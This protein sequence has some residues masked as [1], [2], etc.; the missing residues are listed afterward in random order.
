M[1]LCSQTLIFVYVFHCKNSWTLD[2]TQAF[3]S[4][5]D[6][7]LALWICSTVNNYSLDNVTIFI[8]GHFCIPDRWIIPVEE[9][10]SKDDAIDVD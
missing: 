6:F 2:P 8:E 10:L 7:F 1:L 5:A 9:E 3:L 4:G